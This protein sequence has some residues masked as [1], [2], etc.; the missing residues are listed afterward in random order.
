MGW[1]NIPS[2][3]SRNR[4]TETGKSVVSD[5][6]LQM[7]SPTRTNTF[8][9]LMHSLTSYKRITTFFFSKNLCFETVLN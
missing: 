1:M 8:Y 2:M 7:Q 5:G 3:G 9:D 4:A 6:Q